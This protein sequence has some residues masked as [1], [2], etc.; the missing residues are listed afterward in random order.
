MTTAFWEGQLGRGTAENHTFYL[1]FIIMHYI[2]LVCHIKY[3]YTH[4]HTFCNITKYD[5][6]KGLLTLLQGIV[7]GSVRTIMRADEGKI[8]KK[9]LVIIRTNRR[10]KEEKMSFKTLFY[11]QRDEFIIF[12]SI[13]DFVT[14]TWYKMNNP[15][16]VRK[17]LFIS[18]EHH[19]VFTT[20]VKAALNIVS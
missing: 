5:V 15:I 2:D 17:T 20:K 11:E 13:S 7:R 6:L 19:I 9:L 18:K 3:I 16:I 12:F 4:T 10:S 8:Q 14:P 1:H